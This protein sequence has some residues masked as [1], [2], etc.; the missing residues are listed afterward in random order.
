MAD[1]AAAILAQLHAPDPVSRDVALL[2]TRLYRFSDDVRDYV[3]AEAIEEQL[4]AGSRLR[5]ATLAYVQQCLAA[6][7]AHGQPLPFPGD[8]A[9][10]EGIDAAA[11]L[12]ARCP[13]GWQQVP[14][15]RDPCPLAVI[16]GAPR[17]GTSHLFNV[18]ARTGSFAYFTTA[19]C[20]AWPVR[21]LHHPGRHL[22]TRFGDAVLG[23]DNKR[24]RVIPWLVMPG[25]AEDIWARAVSVYRH[26]AAHRYQIT[27]PRFVQSKILQAATAAHAS[28]FGKP[29]LLVKSPF[30]SFRIGQIEALWGTTARYIHIVRDRRNSADSMRR[31]RFEF[32]RDERLLTAEEAWQMFTDAVCGDA[33]AGRLMTVTHR[34][35]LADP[36]S[37]VAG[38]LGWLGIGDRP[39]T[40]GAGSTADMATGRRPGEVPGPRAESRES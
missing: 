13:Y 31:N 25:E 16:V 10:A 21:N 6:I 37:V 40:R 3:F 18:L 28:F 24:T 23:V 4:L 22:F 12:A 36:G 27:P 34:E 33:P 32:L 29:Q 20:W 35:L 2:R 26:V 7:R 14:L 17:S 5:P 39:P 1:Q 11:E 9:A 8:I 30:N 19:S 15:P 38:I